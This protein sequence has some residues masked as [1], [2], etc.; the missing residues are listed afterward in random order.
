MKKFIPSLLFALLFA[1][2]LAG[3]WEGI[4][5]FC[6][7]SM[8]LYKSWDG[9]NFRGAGPHTDTPRYLVEQNVPPG[10]SVFMRTL[11]ETDALDSM[12]RSAHLTLSWTRSPVPVKFGG[13]S[14]SDGSFA[15]LNNKNE[16]L[17]F[18]GYEKAGQKDEWHLWT[19][20]S[21]EP[22]TF[23]VF[24][25]PPMRKELAGVAVVCILIAFL[26]KYS[27]KKNYDELT[28]MAISNPTGIQTGLV[29]ACVAFFIFTAALTLAHTFSAPNGLGVYGGKAKLF[30]LAG[31]IPEGFFTDAAYSTYQPAYPPGLALLT[32]LSYMISGGCGEWLTQLIPVFAGSVLLW[33]LCRQVPAVW[34]VLWVL[35][36]FS[37]RQVLQMVTLYYAEPFMALF[38]IL[39]WLRVR[40]NA[41]DR[42]GWLLFGIAGLFKNEGLVISC[43]LWGV[44]AI[45]TT[46][47]NAKN[48]GKMFFAMFPLLGKL[49][50]VA[51][52][53]LAWHIFCRLAGATLYDYAPFWEPDWTKFAAALSY[54]AKTAFYKPWN[55]GFAY[56]LAAVVAIRELAVRKKHCASAHAAAFSALTCLVAF[57]YICSLSRAPF[58]EWHLKSSSGR[59]LWTPSLLVICEVLRCLYDNNRRINVSSN[60][61]WE[62]RVVNLTWH[63]HMCYNYSRNERENSDYHPDLRRA[64]KRGADFRGGPQARAGRR[65]TFRRRQF[66]RRNG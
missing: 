52:I 11:S 12:E 44:Y 29:A 5:G 54:M 30:Y 4:C 61:R 17:E 51:A 25:H 22:G 2:T 16:K 62:T 56:P 57:A 48:T 49:T 41:D 9:K 26:V 60:P 35:A 43:A 28:G 58:F 23:S 37:N 50:L 15:I 63:R 20:E 33:A 14:E 21:T 13:L 38:V 47:K 27:K 8:L 40:E 31:G 34:G 64:R 10:K 53:P 19:R 39:G 66:A 18:P 46:M 59:L 65:H 6:K 24:A 1:A 36:A 32:L 42:T 3:N 45:R 7:S 55:Y